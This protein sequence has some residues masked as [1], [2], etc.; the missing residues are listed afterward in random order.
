[1]LWEGFER[2]SSDPSCYAPSRPPMST[3]HNYED[4]DDDSE[5]YFKVKPSEHRR[6]I[7]SY[8]YGYKKQVNKK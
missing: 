1:M 7:G 2:K 6:Q 8:V 5:S 4:N 3:G